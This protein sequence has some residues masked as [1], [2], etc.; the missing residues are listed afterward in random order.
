MLPLREVLTNLGVQNDDQHIIWNSR[1]QSVT[2]IKDTIQIYLKVG[3]ENAKINDKPVIVDAA[4]VNYNSRVYIPARF[5][6]EALGMKVNWDIDSKTISIQSTKEIKSKD[7]KFSIE[8]P[9]RWEVKDKQESLNEI[10]AV[11]KSGAAGMV[12]SIQ[13]K[14]EFASLENWKNGML[15]M[16]QN[17]LQDFILSNPSD[18]SINGNKAVQ[19]TFNA[20]YQNIKLKGT[21]TYIEGNNCYCQVFCSEQISN[22]WNYENDFSLINNSIKGL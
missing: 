10:Q 11:S 1:D 9:D 19:Y 2:V 18:I 3:D 7:G 15:K 13:S 21:L 12:A 14:S 22:F 5:I 16:Y 4:P 6:A 17:K 8:I 20:T